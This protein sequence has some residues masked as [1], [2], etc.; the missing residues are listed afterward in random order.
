ME[1]AV[2]VRLIARD[3]KAL[4]LFGSSQDSV[5]GMKVGYSSFAYSSALAV[6][7]LLIA[8]LFC[9]ST[10]LPPKAQSSQWHHPLASPVALPS[11]KP[12][13]VPFFFR[14]WQSLRN[15]SVSF[16]NSLKPA[17]FISPPRLFMQLPPA[18]GGSPIPRPPLLP[19][20]SALGYQGP[21]FLPRYSHKSPTSSSLSG[22]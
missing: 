17:A 9:S 10:I 18:P 13:G 21:Y 5:P 20:A 8:T 19:Y 14:F 2:A 4:L 16:G 12:A 3:R 11:A 1:M 15:P 7:L 22:Y 6:S